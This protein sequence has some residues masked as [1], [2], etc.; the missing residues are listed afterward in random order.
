MEGS[1]YPRL[2]ESS[3]PPGS[4]FESSSHRT[5]LVRPCLFLRN[6]AYCLHLHSRSLSDQRDMLSMAA[7]R[8][9]IDQVKD[10]SS[11]LICFRDSS[12]LRS[13]WTSSTDRSSLLSRRF[14]FDHELLASK[15]YQGQIRSL[16][17]RAFRK[18]RNLDEFSSLPTSPSVRSIR[19]LE[20]AKSA[21][22]EQQIRQDRL[23]EYRTINLLIL[24]PQI[25]GQFAV[26]DMMHLLQIKEYSRD[27]RESYRR[28]IFSCVYDAMGAILQEL[29]G[30]IV[31]DGACKQRDIRTILTWLGS[32]G[33]NALP[34]DVAAAIASLWQNKAVKQCYQSCK[35]RIYWHAPD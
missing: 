1:K 7:S 10:D 31:L 17:R 9:I 15:V 11:S 14:G 18:D 35:H 28:I 6:S 19:K 5:K 33:L 26:L 27:L 16:M 24:G 22:I 34:Q 20:M 21:A 32:P 8:S 23:S 12:S 3:T 13:L 4:S 25:S 2:R 29:N 30:T